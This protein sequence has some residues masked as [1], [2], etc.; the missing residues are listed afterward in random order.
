MSTVLC[1]LVLDA[2]DPVSLG[3]FWA[4]ALGW[5]ADPPDE[6]GLALRAPWAPEPRPW[7]LRLRQAPASSGRNR[8]HLDLSSTSDAEQTATVERLVDLGAEHVDIGQGDVPWVVLADPEGN[9]FCVLEPRET[10]A[11]IGTLAAVVVSSPQPH[12]LASFWRIA[13]GWTVAYETTDVVGLRSPDDGGPFLE[14]VRS[15]AD[16]SGDR[17][18]LEVAVRRG[19]DQSG[20]VARL[21]RL[22]ASRLP[23]DG[24]GTRIPALADPEGNGF[25]VRAALEPERRGRWRGRIRPGGIIGRS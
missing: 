20:D 23:P 12:Q 9:E 1:G 10:Y 4:S 24:D 2:R 8:L 18:R 3:R 17:L 22:G 7:C 19:D 16:G 5:E 14:F 21:V 11:G 15:P 6:A 25:L 13:S